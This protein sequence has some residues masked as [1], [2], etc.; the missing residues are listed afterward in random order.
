[1]NLFNKKSNVQITMKYSCLTG[2]YQFLTQVT[3]DLTLYCPFFYLTFIC[4]VT[5]KEIYI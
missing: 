1:M 3:G 4:V 2:K 5:E